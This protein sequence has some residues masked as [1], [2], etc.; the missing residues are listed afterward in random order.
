[1]NSLQLATTNLL[2]VGA[3]QHFFFCSFM[4]CGTS[5]EQVS[6]YFDAQ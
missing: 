4:L 5:K 1:M 2:S 6:N 3:S